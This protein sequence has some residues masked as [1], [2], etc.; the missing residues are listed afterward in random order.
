LDFKGLTFVIFAGF[1]FSTFFFMR[2]SSSPS[3]SVLSQK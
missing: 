2:D 3:P 1:F